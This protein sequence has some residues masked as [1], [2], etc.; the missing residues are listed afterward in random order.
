MTFNW[1][2]FRFVSGISQCFRSS[3][4]WAKIHHSTERHV[5]RVQGGGGFLAHLVASSWAVFGTGIGRLTLRIIPCVGPQAGQYGVMGFTCGLV[6][7]G[8]ASSL[9]TLK[10]YDL[11]L[12]VTCGLAVGVGTS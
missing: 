11:A 7:Q 1:I 3:K 5:L 6:G 2:H 8:I 12:F 4:P 10:R 9:M